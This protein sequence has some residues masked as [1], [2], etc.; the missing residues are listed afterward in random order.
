MPGLERWRA[1][2]K[3]MGLAEADDRRYRDVMARYAEP[4][5]HYHTTQHLDECFARLDEAAHL[6][7]RF[8]EV[9]LALWFHDAVYDV[10]G[11]DNEAKSADWARAAVS[12][13]GLDASVAGRV[14]A[15]I[16]ATRHDVVPATSDAMLLVDVD[17]SI[18]GAPP[19]RF[20]EYERQ[21]HDEYAWVPDALFR[22]KRREILAAF[23]ARPRVFNTEHFRK[24]YEA[25]ARTNLQRSI[26]ALAG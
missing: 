24:A 26:A 19:H 12:G 18:L 4:Q 2:W 7:E 10:R 9:E 21:I 25:Q 17:L 13:A 23:L 5:R 6:A 1:S 20:D 3:G 11:Q 15:L 22:Q 16:M 14:H 8:H